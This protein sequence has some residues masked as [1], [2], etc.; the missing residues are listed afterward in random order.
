MCSACQSCRSEM[1]KGCLCSHCLRKWVLV[2]AR[3][4]IALAPVD[5]MLKANNIGVL[6]KTLAFH[7]SVNYQIRVPEPFSND[8]H[9]DLH[10]DLARIGSQGHPSGFDSI[11]TFSRH[12]NVSMTGTALC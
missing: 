2:Q 5:P 3:A 1:S 4:C 11:S 8:V 12:L 7:T 6:N 10:A 9:E